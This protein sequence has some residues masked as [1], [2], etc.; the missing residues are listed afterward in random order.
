MQLLSRAL[1]R[2]VLLL[3]AR[4]FYSIDVFLI[5]LLCVHFLCEHAYRVSHNQVFE[6][7]LADS[8]VLQLSFLKK[9]KRAIRK[10]M[11]FKQDSERKIKREEA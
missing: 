6:A 1:N 10:S 5:S 2:T 8:G 3:C 4:E 7:F 9:K 11:N